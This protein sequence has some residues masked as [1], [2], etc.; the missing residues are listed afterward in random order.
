[1]RKGFLYIFLI[2]SLSTYAETN[3][4]KQFLSDFTSL[5]GN[6]TLLEE[7]NDKYVR[8]QL[9]DSCTIELYYCGE[10]ECDAIFVVLTVC[11]PQCSSIARVY[12]KLGEYLF[13]YEPTVQSIFPL[14]TIDKETGRI[15]WIDNDT[16]NYQSTL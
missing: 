16:W 11:A 10:R 4:I 15:T 14:A 6:I 12:N 3:E 8:S 1:M 7:Y 9:N 5:G 13:P 2:L